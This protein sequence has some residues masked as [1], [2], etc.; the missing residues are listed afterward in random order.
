MFEKNK[1]IQTYTNLSTT[2]MICPTCK[3]P[4]ILCHYCGGGFYW[5]CSRCNSTVDRTE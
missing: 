5:F 2:S 3:T 4:M 1:I